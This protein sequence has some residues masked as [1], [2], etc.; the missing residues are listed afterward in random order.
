MTNVLAVGGVGL[1]RKPFS[2]AAIGI[3]LR[4]DPHGAS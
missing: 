3:A 4:R 2:L 1:L